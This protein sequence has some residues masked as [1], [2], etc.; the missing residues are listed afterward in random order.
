MNIE[1]NLIKGIIIKM[2]QCP[3][4]K[5]D[6]IQV[7]RPDKREETRSQDQKRWPDKR[8]QDPK[9]RE[10]K[11]SQAKQGQDQKR[12]PKGG[13]KDQTKETT[14]VG[15]WG[16]DQTREEKT[17]SVGWWGPIVDWGGRDKKPHQQD[18]GP[19]AKP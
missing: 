13:R 18:G 12:T 17:T 6:K 1:P 5:E 14:S 11:R 19:G 4:K 10:K 7:R 9:R 2:T 8:S 16:P 3:D 15:W